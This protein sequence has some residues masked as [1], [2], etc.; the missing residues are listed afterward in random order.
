MFERFTEHARASVTAAM[1]IA[2]DVGARQLE[3]VHLLAA[4]AEAGG[5]G[6]DA[7]EFMGV[8][9]LHLGTAMRDDPLDA[10]ALAGL[11]VDLD[12]VRTHAERE[13]G[14]GALDRA[15]RRTRRG[16]LPLSRPAK[17]AF[18]RALKEAAGRSQ[19]WL[20][21]GHLVLGLLDVDAPRVRAVLASAEVD[22]G[23]LRGDVER[24]I[25]ASAA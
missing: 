14:A 7:L 9:S 20:D 22:L 21:T 11:G 15:P 5:P 4:I 17:A 19:R 12:E 8:E 18:G 6:G 2:E 16:R 23:A 24:R 25:A 13:F 3:P 1:A 10:D